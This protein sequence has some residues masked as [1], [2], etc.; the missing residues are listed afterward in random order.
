MKYKKVKR[1]EEDP[2]GRVGVGDCNARRGWN[3]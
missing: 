3:R 2:L 1:T